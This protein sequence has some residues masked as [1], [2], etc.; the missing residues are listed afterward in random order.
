M[1]FLNLVACPGDSIIVAGAPTD[2]AT[3]TDTGQPDDTEVIGPGDS[4]N[5][6]DSGDETGDDSGGNNEEDDAA[7]EAFYDLDTIQQVVIEIE[8][9]TI[10]AMDDEAAYEYSVHPSD[11]QL[12]YFHAILSLNGQALGDVGIRLKG[13]STFQ[14]WDAKPSLKVKFDE[15][16]E[17]I[18][19]AGL[20]RATFNNMTGD[21]AMAREVIGYTFWRD[22]G[23]AVPRANFAQVYVAVDGRPAEYYGMFTNLESM[24]S[25]WIERNY[26]DDAG[27]LWEGNDS[28]DFNRRGL[29]HLELVAG[30]NDTESLANARDAVQNHGD[31][32][33]T[34]ANVYID[35]DQ[36]LDFWAMSVSIGNRDGYPYNLNDFFV[37]HD[38][39]EG[40]MNFTPWGMDETWDTA[41]PA[42][43]Y[44]LNG[45]VA[46]EC[47][48]DTVN[49]L[50]KFYA[51]AAEAVAVYE[52]SDLPTLAEDVFELTE[53]AMADDTR[54]N[55]GGYAWTTSDV[56]AYRDLLAY[57]IQMYPGWLRARIPIE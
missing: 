16:D 56:R 12:S 43:W 55:W 9:A 29:S 45:D 50:P 41:S 57:R 28:S 35:M 48:D 54:K 31:D 3:P 20:K 4:A 2:S 46:Q 6:I 51:A 1:L 44:S 21:P 19:F 7:Y 22:A 52:T 24:D 27:D 17:T 37:Y 13:S 49:C 38:P 8:Q 5:P 15:W 39:A 34:D 32:Y 36:F 18:R 14:Y 53:Q 33:Y 30:P 26:E 10:G 47:I 23:M 42:Y 11:P 40:K 25:E